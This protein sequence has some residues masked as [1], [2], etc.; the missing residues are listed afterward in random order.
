MCQHTFVTNGQFPVFIP[1]HPQ[2]D[3]LA[4]LGLEGDVVG[5]GMVMVAARMVM[6]GLS[7]HINDGRRPCQHRRI[8]ILNELTDVLRDDIEEHYEPNDQEYLHSLISLP[9]AQR[10]SRTREALRV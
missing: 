1:L 8:L 10:A 7:S 3:Q 4:L 9:K 6:V 2:L 5:M